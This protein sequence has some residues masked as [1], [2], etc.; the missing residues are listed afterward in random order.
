M[1]QPPARLAAGMDLSPLSACLAVSGQGLW[2]VAFAKSYHRRLR[3]W[4]SIKF[5]TRRRDLT[6]VSDRA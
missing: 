4:S 6:T 2:P 1:A 5:E 3:A